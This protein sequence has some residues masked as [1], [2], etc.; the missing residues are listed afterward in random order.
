MTIRW[1]ARHVCI[2]FQVDSNWLIVYIVGGLCGYL[3]G[4]VRKKVADTLHNASKKNNLSRCPFHTVS[5]YHYTPAVK[6]LWEALSV[7]PKCPV[8]LA[9]LFRCPAKLSRHLHLLPAS[10]R[11]ELRRAGNPL[12]LPGRSTEA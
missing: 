12:F 10:S 2:F 8:I 7:S 4:F 5:Y 6:W 9:I 3:W 11:G 1:I